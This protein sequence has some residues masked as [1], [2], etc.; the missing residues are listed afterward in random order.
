MSDNY[1]GWKLFDKITIVTRA[2][3]YW[4]NKAYCWKETGESQGFIA[5]P[6]NKK[7]LD[8]A[9][10]WG[11]VTRY[12]Y[13]EVDGKRTCTGSYDIPPEEYTY[14]NK[15]FILELYDSANNSCEGGKLS[16]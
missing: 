15:D 3:T 9:R 10:K 1:K 16:F 12:T 8:T 2:I 7:Q 11:T 6:T 5:D 14:E 13:E 4:D